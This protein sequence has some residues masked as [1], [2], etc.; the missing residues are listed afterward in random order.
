[1]MSFALSLL[2][3]YMIYEITSY[4]SLFSQ[5]GINPNSTS[6]I[7]MFFSLLLPCILFFL[8]PIFSSFSR[9]NEFEA[10]N[11]AKEFS[12][13]RD[14]ISSLKKLYKENLTLLKTS[15]IYSRVYNSHPTV[16]ERINNLEL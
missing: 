3:F 9:K 5:L 15:P 14:L 8:N 11:Y 6:E 16:F 10:D 4:H 1:M 7:V 12:N 13:K 2:G